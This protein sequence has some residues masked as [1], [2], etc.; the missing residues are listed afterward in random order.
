MN[1]LIPLALLTIALTGCSKHSEL[2]DSMEDMGGAYKA[3]KNS[4]DLAKIKQD[5]ETFKASVNT[6]GMQ[7]VKPEDQAVF[8]EGIDELTAAVKQVDA[9]IAS[10]DLAK[11]KELLK[12]FGELRNKYHDKLGVKKD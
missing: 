12:G 7:M 10:G 8:D 2:H 4:D 1:K 9:A 3:M 6:A 5:W 11:T